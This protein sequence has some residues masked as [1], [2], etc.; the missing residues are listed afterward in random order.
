MN[1]LRLPFFL[2]F[3][4]VL[5]L[6]GSAFAEN[7]FSNSTMETTSTWKGDRK[8]DT[9]GDNRVLKLEANSRKPVSFYQEVK[10]RDIKDLE[11][12][13]RYKSENYKGRGFQTRGER[14]DGS[15]TYRDRTLIADGE[16]HVVTWSFSQI[17]DSREI[18]FSIIL[19]EGEG[20]V[21]FD[22]VTVEG[23]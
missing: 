14:D 4:T 1:I 3:V 19:M 10:T 11:F 6:A 17:N 12:K 20:E 22:D 23:R 8:Y 2:A 21:F 9:E 18:Q 7:L 16:W 13:F 5:L 15:S